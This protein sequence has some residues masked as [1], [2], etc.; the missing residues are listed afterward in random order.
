MD[1]YGSMIDNHSVSLTMMTGNMVNLTTGRVYM[2]I[3]AHVLCCF[4]PCICLTEICILP[5]PSVPALAL[6]IQADTS[7]E[8]RIQISMGQIQNM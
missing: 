1:A 4:C 3:L 2:Y 5:K 7:G 8:G 6:Q